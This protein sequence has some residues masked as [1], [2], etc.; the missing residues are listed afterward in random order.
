M[1]FISDEFGIDLELE[2]AVGALLDLG[3]ELAAQAVA[4][5]AFGH[6]AAGKL[7]RDLAGLVI[8][9]RLLDLLARVHH[10]RAVLHDRLAK[11]LAREQQHARALL[12]RLD[13]HGV[14]VR[15]QPRRTVLQRLAIRADHGLAFIGVQERVV[16]RGHRSFEH[17]ARREV[18]VE[19]ARVGARALHRPR[20]FLAVV[21]ERPRDDFRRDAFSEA[22]DRDR[23]D[24]MSR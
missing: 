18:H 21:L 6:G 15:Q 19:V 9:D 3:G 24:G 8:G 4:E 10:E 17:G 7:V 16:A 5:V 14:A 23:A 20:G 22:R 1:T 2:R 12:A 13:A 11:R